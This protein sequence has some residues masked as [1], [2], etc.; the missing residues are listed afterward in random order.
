MDFDDLREQR[1]WLV[2][3][4]ADIAA[5]EMAVFAYHPKAF[6]ETLDLLYHVR[7]DGSGETVRRA[8]VDAF[9]EVIRPCIVAPPGESTMSLMYSVIGSS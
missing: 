3:V 8:A 1:D 4:A 7:P 6:A 2:R 9:R 5:T